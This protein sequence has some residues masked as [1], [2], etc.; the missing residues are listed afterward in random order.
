MVQHRCLQDFSDH[1]EFAARVI[2]YL[3]LLLG[4]SGKTNYL[5]AHEKTGEYDMVHDWSVAH[6]V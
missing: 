5:E 1:G 6:S 2:C 3:L 4:K